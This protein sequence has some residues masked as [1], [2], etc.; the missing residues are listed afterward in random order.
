MIW[1]KRSF[2]E[3]SRED[4]PLSYKKEREKIAF[5]VH[6]N[7]WTWQQKVPTSHMIALGSQ[8]SLQTI[9]TVILICGVVWVFPAVFSSLVMVTEMKITQ[10][11][12]WSFARHSVMG[13]KSITMAGD[14]EIKAS[15]T[16]DKRDV[17]NK[18]IIGFRAQ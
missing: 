7:L 15:G 10:N 1:G 8:L 2:L 11:S 12:A 5:W 18:N 3:P 17:I 13:G 16:K 4:P 9:F 6:G 14:D